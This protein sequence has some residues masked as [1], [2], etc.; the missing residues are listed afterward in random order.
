MSRLIASNLEVK[1]NLAMSLLAKQCIYMIQADVNKQQGTPTLVIRTKSNTDHSPCIYMIAS[2]SSGYLRKISVRSVTDPGS[3][4]SRTLDAN[5]TDKRLPSIMAESALFELQR[6]TR[7]L[8]PKTLYEFSLI[9]DNI[10]YDTVDKLQRIIAGSNVVIKFVKT[11]NRSKPND[12]P[13]SFADCLEQ[14]QTSIHSNLRTDDACPACNGEQ[15][16]NFKQHIQGV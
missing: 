1:K 8:D 11:F 14:A 16:F 9:S 7:D 5:W 10:L 3:F 15:T 12:E 4:N 6:V 2:W 13:E